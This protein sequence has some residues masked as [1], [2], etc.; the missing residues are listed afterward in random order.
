MSSNSNPTSDPFHY[1]LLDRGIIPDFLLR[2]AIRYLC[3]ERLQWVSTEDL[4]KAQ[5]RKTQYIEG[6]K[7]RPIAIHTDKANEQHYEV[8]IIR[9]RKCLGG[10]WERVCR[11]RVGDG[12]HRYGIHYT[13]SR[14]V[15]GFKGSL[16][17]QDSMQMG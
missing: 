14:D 11:A 10:S 1:A 2:I 6:L 16:I 17:C 8:G 4:T 15:R 9:A 12:A 5:E 7:E 3:R 13:R